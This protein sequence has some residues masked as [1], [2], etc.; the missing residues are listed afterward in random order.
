MSIVILSKKILDIVQDKN[1]F[2]LVKRLTILI[3]RSTIKDVAKDAGVS[4]A[5]VSLVIHNNERISK[6]TK[7]KVLRS[8]KNLKYFPTKSARDLA[9]QKTGNIGF[10]LTDDHFLKTEPFYTR[11]FLGSEFEA[12][13]GE[14]YILLTTAKSE[15]RETDPLP[16]FILEKN[17][18]GIIVAGKIPNSLLKK[19]I[20]S[21]L[22][23]VFVDFVPAVN[24]YPLVLIDNIQGG[25]KATEYL[26]NLGHMKVGF[27]AG[28]I[29]HPSI[30]DRLSGYKTALE[31]SG[32]IIDRDLIITD[33]P[34]PDRQNG[35]NSAKKLFKNRK[36]I[37][38]IFACNDAMA[39]GAM[40]F[41]K[42]AGYKIPEDVS[43]IGFDDV[44]ADL[45]I[46]PPLT[47]IRVPKIEMGAEALRIMVQ[48][49]KQKK[50]IPKK[51]LVP[52]ELIIRKSTMILNGKNENQRL[53]FK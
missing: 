20:D 37:T 22:P 26:I 45:M 48:T 11:I 7:K 52:V 27:L 14:Y 30:K 29:S 13:E 39:I 1:Y 43:I 51:I 32:I 17:V 2:K 16:R 35:Y 5:T 10:I 38:G 4:I 9:S 44:E 34:Y 47:T 42:D 49:L 28:D 50:L 21:N 15:Y 12:R 24:D 33:S 40:Q 3:M 53:S 41:L 18:D 31:Q 19:I 46:D 36:N 8:I 25:I 23:L 6:E